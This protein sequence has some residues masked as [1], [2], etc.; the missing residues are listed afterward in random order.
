[1]ILITSYPA[2][3]HVGLE[4]GS[5]LYAATVEFKDAEL[6]QPVSVAELRAH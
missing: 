3:R 5:I 4:F 2:K 6:I 1:M